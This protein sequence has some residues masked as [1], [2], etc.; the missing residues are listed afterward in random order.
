M[1]KENETLVKE[2]ADLTKQVEELQK[3]LKIKEVGVGSVSETKT[4]VPSTTTTSQSGV[5]G[6]KPPLST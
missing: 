4:S 5:G 1:R 6:T 2:K 3:Q